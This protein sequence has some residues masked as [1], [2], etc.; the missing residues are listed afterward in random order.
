MVRLVWRGRPRRRLSDAAGRES[1]QIAGIARLRWRQWE[2]LAVIALQAGVAAGGSWWL[3]RHVG[4]NPDPVFAPSAAVGTIVAAL[5]QRTRRT[6]ELLVGTGLGLLIGDGLV[7]FVGTGAWQIGLIVTLALGIALA[8]GGRRGTVIAQVGGTAVLIATLSSS[9][10][11]L[12]L[13]RAAGAAVG[14]V[15]ALIVVGLLLPLHPV[16]VIRRAAEPVFE[17]LIEQLCA[18]ERSLRGRDPERMEAAMRSLRGMAAQVD[19]MN[20]AVQGAEEVVRIAPARWPRRED[21]DWYARG[22]RNLSLVIDDAQGLA[23]RAAT[24]LRYDEPLPA[25]LA[26]AVGCLTAAV[27][28]LREVSRRRPGHAEMR[29]LG[30]LAA[31][32]AGSAAGCGLGTFGE[33]VVTQLRITASDLLKASGCSVPGADRRIRLATRVGHERSAA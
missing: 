16:R 6:I 18:V 29:R 14:S 8:L 15:T 26:D 24:L 21:V 11:N 30:M 13:P 25:A 9:H 3:A 28:Q 4:G 33:A 31:V 19:R 2:I 17:Q 32:H 22:A 23:R 10:R 20:E 7:Y 12:E 5:G 1:R 27:R